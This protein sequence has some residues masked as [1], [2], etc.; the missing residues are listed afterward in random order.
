[1]TKI[2][3]RLRATLKR[4]AYEF[5]PRM[6][7]WFEHATGDDPIAQIRRLA[8][9]G[10]YE[11]S[12]AWFRATTWLS[13][14][15]WPARSIVFSLQAVSAFGRIATARSGEPRA[16]QLL[17][18]LWLANRHNISPSSYYK[19]QLD[20]P[21]NRRAATLF[22]QRHE[23]IRLLSKL[24]RCVETD[25]I[26]DK[27]RFVDFCREHSLPT[28]QVF[29]RF[30]DGTFQG[31][32]PS[33]GLPRHDLFLKPTLTH[34][35]SGV[36]KWS[37][38]PGT[39]QWHFD[40]AREDE[41]GLLERARGISLG[42]GSIL[43][44][45]ITVCDELRDLAGQGA[46]TIRVVTYRFPGQPTEVLTRVL[47]MPTGSHCADNHAA[48]GIAA[49]VDRAG[50]LGPATGVLGSEFVG[51][52]RHPDSGGQIEGRTITR[53]PEIEQLCLQAHDRT[54]DVPFIG[55][56]VLPGDRGILL[57]EANPHWCADLVQMPSH[58]RL[59]ESAL[60]DCYLTTHARFCQAL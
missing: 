44:E 22:L 39:N 30:A 28:P 9:D 24:N 45:A 4:F 47:K 60:V 48:G 29:A 10:S 35:S 51:I 15:T 40:G 12:T 7:P 6:L 13:T 34:S 2:R 25:Q 42:G 21:E 58:T 53:L 38:E 52:T 5:S 11:R 27:A 18:I 1:M 59:G 26:D 16:K 14:Y 17:S 41:A 57:L 37:F 32:P 49:H 36:E 8:V 54:K 56:D 50:R 3:R 23:L 46:C 31:V 55:W 20:R 43:Q 19:F 33:G